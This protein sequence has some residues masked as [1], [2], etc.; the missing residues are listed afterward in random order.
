MQ[1][2]WAGLVECQAAKGEP[3]RPSIGDRAGDTGPARCRG[4]TA[5]ASVLRGP[6]R[7]AGSFLGPGIIGG[8]ETGRAAAFVRD[9]QFCRD[10]TR[11]SAGVPE[12]VFSRLILPIC[13]R[14]GIVLANPLV[15][16][17]TEQI[18]HAGQVFA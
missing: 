5:T 2:V 17:V 9:G 14:S 12:S 16:C 7:L 11:G 18:G 4:R 6:L 1:R 8:K 13:Q 3:S 10:R 15:L